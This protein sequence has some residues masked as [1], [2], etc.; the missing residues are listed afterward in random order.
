M[1]LQTEDGRSFLKENDAKNDTKLNNENFTGLFNRPLLKDRPHRPL[2]DACRLLGEG[3]LG[4]SGETVG[5]FED[6]IGT[7]IE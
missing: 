5:P 6:R 2:C 3:A 4:Q 7:A 1:Y